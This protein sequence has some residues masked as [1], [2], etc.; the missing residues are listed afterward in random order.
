MPPALRRLWLCPRVPHRSPVCGCPGDPY[1]RRYKR[2]HEEHHLQVLGSLERRTYE[3]RG[4]IGTG[5]RRSSGTR[6]ATAK[7]LLDRGAESVILADL[8]TSNGAQAKPCLAARALSFPATSPTQTPSRKA[9]ELAVAH[10]PLRSVVHC[11]GRGGDR[12]RIINKND[13]P[14]AS[15]ALPRYSRPTS[16]GL[17]TSFVCPPR[18]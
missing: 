10:G 12:L 9:L 5:H 11:A 1:L 15:T 14:G 18:S 17:T 6:F 13:S 16:S 2:G 3:N 4:Y 7:L 8:P